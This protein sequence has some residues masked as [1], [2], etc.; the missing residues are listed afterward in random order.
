MYYTDIIP[1][2][3]YILMIYSYVFCIYIYTDQLTIYTVIY[4]HHIYICP[5]V[6][7]SL[8]VYTCQLYSIIGSRD[9]GSS[10]LFRR[11]RS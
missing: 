10:S 11:R 5:L 9:D 2:I 4:I 6:S 7:L 1:V 8:Y 3:R